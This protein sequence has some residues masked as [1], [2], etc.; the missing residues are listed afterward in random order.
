MI[1]ST[2][3]WIKRSGIASAAALAMAQIQS[4]ARELPYAMGVD[5]KKQKLFSIAIFL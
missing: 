4:L 1:H 3:Q 2:A 5:I